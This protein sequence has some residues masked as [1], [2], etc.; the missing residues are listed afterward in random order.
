M[1]LARLTQKIEKM[2]SA[3]ELAMRM[4]SYEQDYIFT[5]NSFSVESFVSISS[6]DTEYDIVF[7]ATNCNRTLIAMPT[8]WFT[9]AGDVTINLGSCTSYANGTEIS[10][11][12]RNYRYAASFSSQIVFKYNVTPTAYSAG[13]TNLLVGSAATNQNS[14]GGGLQGRLPIILETGIIYIFR[15]ANNSGQDIKFAFSIHWYEI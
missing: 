14:G 2:T 5:G 13:T 9:T 8:N 4:A 3:D 15:V 6:G 10:A 1:S 11:T 12:N 7:D